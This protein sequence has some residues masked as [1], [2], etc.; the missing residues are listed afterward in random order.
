[1]PKG[2]S[3]YI[4]GA[5]PQAGKSVVLLGIMEL[6]SRH[7]QKLGFFRP[8][9][10]EGETR[11]N[12]IRLVS[13]RYHLPFPDRIRYGMT[14]E[15]ARR[16]VGEEKYNELLKR[17]LEEYRSLE[18]DCD[19]VVCLGT[20]F[21]DIPPGLALDFNIDVANNLGALAAPVATGYGRTAQEV[22]RRSFV[23]LNL[24][25]TKRC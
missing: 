4:F 12:A 24:L 9:V 20:G 14:L 8:L 1:M 21:H 25:E 18:S 5:E 13:S 15:E 7:V 10:R 23:L 19:V 3:I 22:V 16:L 2:K 11:D 6:L 17:I